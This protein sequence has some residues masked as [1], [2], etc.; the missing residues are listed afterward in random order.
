MEE[1]RNSRR[2]AANQLRT[3]SDGIVLGNATSATLEYFWRKV[4]CLLTFLD[5]KSS[6]LRLGSTASPPLPPPPP[7]P[8]PPDSIREDP[9]SFS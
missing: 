6:I 3:S 9:P 2:A 8:P 4:D 5:L 7:P 1:E